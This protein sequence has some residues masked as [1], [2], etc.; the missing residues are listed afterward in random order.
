MACMK[1]I[2]LTR[3]WRAVAGCRPYSVFH[4]L[5]PYRRTVIPDTR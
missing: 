3:A 4:C 5:C 2:V 1:H